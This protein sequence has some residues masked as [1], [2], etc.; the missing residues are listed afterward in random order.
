MLKGLNEVLVERIVG[1][2]ESGGEEE[3]INQGLSDFK[4]LVDLD[5]KYFPNGEAYLV[6]THPYNYNSV[7]FVSKSNDTKENWGSMDSQ[8]V[9]TALGDGT[10]EMQAI[11]GSERYFIH[12][13]SKLANRGKNNVAMKPLRKAKGKPAALIKKVEA[14]E[15]ARKEFIDAN[16]EHLERETH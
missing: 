13:Q 7:S 8:I 9:F 11:P 15:K 6:Q 5:K 2:S 3:L 1:I 12:P 14:W 16:K 10:Y 4:E